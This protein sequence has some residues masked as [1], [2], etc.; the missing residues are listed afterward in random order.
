MTRLTSGLHYPVPLRSTQYYNLLGYSVSRAT[1]AHSRRGVERVRLLVRLTARADAAYDN[2]Y[3]HKLRGRIWRALQDTEF[4]ARHDSGEPPGFAYSNPFPPRDMAE[5]D[6]RTLLISSPSEQLLAPIASNLLQNRELNIGEMPFRVTDLSDLNPDVGEPGTSGTL[7]TGTGVLVRIPRD[8]LDEYGIDTVEGNA[9]EYW[10]P[11]HPLEPFRVQIENNLDR[12]HGLFMPDYLPGP[13][14]RDG[15]LFDSYELIKDFAVPLTVTQG[16]EREFVLTK[17]RFGYNV[18]DDH[19][20]RHLNLAL[21]TGI[22]ERN[23]LGLGFLNKRI[24]D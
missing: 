7:E 4:E 23:S 16:V 12:K 11:E 6:N 1:V 17:W 24:D 15:Q 18:R 20:R 10:R 8:R 19:H 3:H 14:D 9:A 2:A 22:G 13:T 5:G 21:S